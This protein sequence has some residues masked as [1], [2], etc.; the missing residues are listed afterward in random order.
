MGFLMKMLP[1]FFAAAALS[2]VAAPASAA[3]IVAGS[4]WQEDTVFEANAP[5]AG[6]PWTFSLSGPGVF[7]VTDAFLT[8]DSLW[9]Y[10]GATLLANSALGAKSGFGGSTPYDLGWTSAAYAKIEY[11][12]DP[13][14]YAFTIVGDGLGGLPAGI[15]VRLD[16]LT[17]S[18]VPEPATWGLMIVGFGL[19][20][21][22]LRSS[23]R[24]ALALAPA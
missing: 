20:G 15:G 17:T 14:S 19:M 3:V 5:T 21:A 23:R 18:P 12:L 9:L 22:A 1:A 4:G 7:R 16:S 2:V 10:D 24:R 11:F 13:G 6:S 8:G